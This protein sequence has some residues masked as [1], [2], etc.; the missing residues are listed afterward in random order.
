MRRGAVFVDV[1]IDQGG[2]SETSHPTTHSDPIY[3]VEGV[4]HYAVTNMPGAVPRTATRALTL[5]TLPY[6]L[7]IADLGW[8]GAAKKNA[9]LAKG[10]NLVEGNVTHQAVAGALNLPYTSLGEVL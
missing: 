1:S 3:D 7:E 2:C 4:I 9:A 10:I 8:K 5:N 6:V